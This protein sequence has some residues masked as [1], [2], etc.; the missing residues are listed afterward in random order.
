MVAPSFQSYKMIVA[1]PFTKNGKLYVTVEHPNTHN[2]RD[3]RWYSDKEYAKAYGN[4]SKDKAEVRLTPEQKKFWKPAEVRSIE[5]LSTSPRI[6]KAS[7]AASPA[8]AFALVW[9]AYGALMQERSIINE[10]S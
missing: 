10:A 4:K 1:E 5:V 2:H 7:V 3:V 6:L 8:V 9:Q